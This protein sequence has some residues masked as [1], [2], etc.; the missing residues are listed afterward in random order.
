MCRLRRADW[1]RATPG[2]GAG[3][4]DV[5]NWRRM[6]EAEA[7]DTT[8]C[9]RLTRGDGAW[10]LKELRRRG[11]EGEGV[12][13]PAWLRWETRKNTRHKARGTRHKAQG[14]RRKAQGARRKTNTQRAPPIRPAATP[15]KTAGMIMWMTGAAGKAKRKMRCDNTAESE[16]RWQQQPQQ[17]APAHT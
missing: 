5:R 11:R 15:T 13:A 17:R 4:G 1:A 3:E 10:A 16:Q 8:R 2:D 14:A 6:C 12:L 7:A 9:E